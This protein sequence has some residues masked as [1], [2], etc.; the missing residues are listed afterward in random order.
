MTV[1]VTGGLGFIGSHLVDALLT[2]GHEVTIV[3][4]LLSNAVPPENYAHK[5]N[6]IISRVEDYMPTERFDLLFHLASVVG[7]AGVLAH[8]GRISRQMVESTSRMIDMALDMGARLVDVSTSE[9][10]GRSGHLTED[11]PKVV[12]SQVTVRLEYG[13]GKLLTEIMIENTAKVHPL[14]WVIIRPFNVAGPR[15]Q[16]TGG[17]VT[18]RFVRAAVH[19]ED[20]T[21]F[22]TG[23]QLRAFTHVYDIVDGILLANRT[24]HVNQVYNL[25]NPNNEITI[26]RYAELINSLCGN[27]SRLVYTDGKQIFGPLFEEAFDKLPNSSK[28]LALLHWKPTRSLEDIILDYRDDYLASLGDFHG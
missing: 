9:V 20:I 5:C 15:Q 24:E 22:D 10:Y 1:L 26:R 12:N 28:A 25:G 13:V 3:D 18:P 2:E 16:P 6:V 4:C 21:I 8:A 19:G 11:A 17:F 27:K 14:Q 7:P 23:Q